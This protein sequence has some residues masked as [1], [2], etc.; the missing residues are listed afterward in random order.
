MTS[1]PGFGNSTSLPSTVVQPL[2]ILATKRSG[3]SEYAVAGGLVLELELGLMVTDAQ[4][5]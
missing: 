2:S 5:M 3:R 1:G 4:L